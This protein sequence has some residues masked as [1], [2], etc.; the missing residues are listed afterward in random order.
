[1]DRGQWTEDRQNVIPA[2]AEIQKT[3]VGGQKS[4]IGKS[5]FLF[6]PLF[7]RGEIGGIIKIKNQKSVRK[8]K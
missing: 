3:E 2:E 7:K 6:P 5:P 1:V 8:I 4:E